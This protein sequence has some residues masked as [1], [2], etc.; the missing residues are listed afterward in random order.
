MGY[1]G[2]GNK[3]SEKGEEL[4]EIWQRERPDVIEAG[5]SGHIKIKAIFCGKQNCSKCPHSFYAY[6]KTKYYTEKYLGKCDKR[7][8]PR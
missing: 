6:Y 2:W 4:F 3:K 1:Q 5:E 7:G 8:L